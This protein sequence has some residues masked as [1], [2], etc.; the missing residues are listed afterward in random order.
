MKDHELEQALKRGQAAAEAGR[1]PAFDSVWADAGRRVAARRRRYVAGGVAAAA[2]V[3][4]VAAGLLQSRQPAWEYVDPEDFVT[5]TSW[6]APSDVLL[7]EY[8]IDIYEEIPVLI[9]STE[10]DGGTLL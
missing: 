10:I 3:T 9:E 5:S 6:H 1:V 8:R 7:P 2:I 4:V